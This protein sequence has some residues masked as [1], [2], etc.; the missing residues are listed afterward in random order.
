MS[1]RLTSLLSL[2]LTILLY[3][4]TTA[5]TPISPDFTTPLTLSTFN[6]SIPISLNLTTPLNLSTFNLSTDPTGP[7]YKCSKV[8]LFRTDHRPSWPECYRAIRQ[9]P[10]THDPGTFHT[11]GL[12]DVWRLPRVEKFGRCRAV[13]EIE[14]RSREASSWVAVKSR[15]DQLSIECR[16]HSGEGGE[17]T[18]G[19]MLLAPGAKVK[20]S[21]LGPKDRDIPHLTSE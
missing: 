7:L 15:L 18:G 9:L 10:S 5:S 14:L 1:Y 3:A 13:V 16:R 20:V 8:G 12:N 17:R 4:T 6:H 19:W 21:L 11:S 2:L